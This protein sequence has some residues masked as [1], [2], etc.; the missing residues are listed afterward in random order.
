MRKLLVIILASLLVPGFSGPAA[1]DQKEE[2]I[3]RLQANL[4]FLASDELEGRATATHSEKIAA[5]FIAAELK[6][7]GVRPFGENG[8]YFQAVP[9]V[10]KVLTS[11]STLSLS[12]GNAEEELA[13]GRDFSVWGEFLPGV[14]DV[15]KKHEMVFVGYGISAAEYNYDDYAGID[16]K[17]KVVVLL[18]GEPY[19]EDATYFN[20]KE[21][22]PYSNTISKYFLAASKG[23]AGILSV[24]DEKAMKDSARINARSFGEALCF[25][26]ALPLK[27][28]FV[29]PPVIFLY[30]DGAAKV[31]RNEKSEYSVIRGSEDS[32]VP[33][34]RF[35]LGKRISFTFSRKV[36][37]LTG[38]N[39]AGIIA[40]SDPELKDEYIILSA[41]FDHLGTRNGQVFNGANDNASGVAAV[42]E[43]MRNLA[44]EKN[45]ARSV[46][47]VFYTGEEKGLLGSTYFAATFAGCKGV[48]ANLNIDMCGRESEGSIFLVGPDLNCPELDAMIHRNNATVGG[49]VFDYANSNYEWLNRSDLVPWYSRGIPVADFGDN[50]QDDYHGPGDDADKINYEKV[51]KT[52]HLVKAV[53]LE[54]ANLDHRLKF[55]G[56]LAK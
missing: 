48:D 27:S 34:A 2:A 6:K 33:A 21:P 25:P 38:R 29:L 43:I 47:A 52:L 26:D 45:N 46:V 42:L 4:G 23:V 8:S 3:L 53:A 30:P 49:F 32:P 15:L 11:A 9:L 14:V 37:D 1:G 54:I 20:G 12:M 56:K 44:L 55:A 19:S 10:A 18:P 7:C 16:V 13:L 22:T 5:Q 31:F 36:T 17:G 28:E 40:G 50:M 39:V 51:F 35:G 41:H 24:V